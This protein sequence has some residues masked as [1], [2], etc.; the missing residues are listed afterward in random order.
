MLFIIEGADG[1]GK[2]TF[3][4]K[5]ASE[6]QGPVTILHRGP[7]E[8]HPLAEYELEL[9]DYRPGGG[10]HIICDRWH[11]GEL[12]YGPVY[13][14]RS[15]LDEP[16]R[17]HVE[18][19]LRAKGALLIHLDGRVTEMKR[20]LEKRGDD[21]IN[22]G[23]LDHLLEA[24]RH[25]RAKTLL[26]WETYTDPD[27]ADACK[28]AMLGQLVELQCVNVAPFET[29]VGQPRPRYLLLGERRAIRPD[30]PSHAACFVPYPA[31]SG[32][33]LMQS[34]PSDLLPWVGI[35]N[36]L[37]ENVRELWEKSLRPRIVCLGREAQR[38]C[39]RVELPHESVPHPQWVRR[40]NTH[41][42]ESYSE[43]IR[44]AC[45]EPAS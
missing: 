24:Y 17:V 40:F 31:T 39:E 14:G 5:L 12:I 7:P 8:R 26:P 23:D 9:D 27:A 16:A 11:L 41:N 43:Q 20:R 34:L 35:A 2:T 13:R 1:V 21:Y 45:L 4:Q 15:R 10:R 38:A 33:Y 42:M 19:F 28:A 44:N 18:L 37:D 3:V 29:Y 6:L 36:A 22:L 32:R 30:L 25:I